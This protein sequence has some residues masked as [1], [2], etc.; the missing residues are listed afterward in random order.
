MNN[1]KLLI[2]CISNSAG[3]EYFTDKLHLLPDF[4]NDLIMDSESGYTASL[5]EIDEKVWQNK[6][7]DPL[8]HSSYHSSHFLNKYGQELCLGDYI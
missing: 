4:I 5:F 2:I 6:H 3:K 8:S 7:N 1:K